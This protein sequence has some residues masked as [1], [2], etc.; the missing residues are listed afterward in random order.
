M[1]S[2]SFIKRI[3]AIAL[4]VGFFLPL[5]RCSTFEIDHQTGRLVQG[6]AADVS[7]FNA[8]EWPSVGSTISLALFGWAALIQ[9]LVLRRSSIE[10]NSGVFAVEVIL[11]MMTVAGISWIVYWGQGIRY[12]ALICY[13][14]IG[15]YLG[16]AIAGRRR[17]RGVKRTAR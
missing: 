7:A 14:A 5:T 17:V 2:A 12:G 6:I 16:A 1:V 8:Y 3:A 15:A 13:A 11:F 9:L 10:S 4:V